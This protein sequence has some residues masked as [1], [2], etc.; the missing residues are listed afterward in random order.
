MSEYIVDYWINYLMIVYVWLLRDGRVLPT[1]CTQHEQGGGQIWLDEV[2][3]NGEESELAECGHANWG[4]ND[5]GH[6]E[7]VGV[8]CCKSSAFLWPRLLLP[9][10]RLR[11]S[12]VSSAFT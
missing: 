5:C 3:C 12:I 8:E 4:V 7:D 10:R 6:G 11:V 1:C 9:N 2:S